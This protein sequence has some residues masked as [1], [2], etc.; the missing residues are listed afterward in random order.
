MTDIVESSLAF[1]ATAVVVLI[2]L[3]VI[4][5]IILLINPS[6]VPIVLSLPALG[7]CLGIIFVISL[8]VRERVFN[9]D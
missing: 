9:N 8:G 1:L 2:V 7:L 6:A 5:G 4:S 3:M